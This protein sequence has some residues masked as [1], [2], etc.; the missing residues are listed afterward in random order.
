LVLRDFFVVFCIIQFIIV[1]L[2]AI[3]RE[4]DKASAYCV[5]TC[6]VP[7]NGTAPDPCVACPPIKA[8]L[9]PTSMEDH[10][11]ITYY[12]C[13]VITFLA[14]IGF[15]GLCNSFCECLAKPAPPPSSSRDTCYCGDCYCRC[16]SPKG[17]CGDGGDDGNATVIILVGIIMVMFAIVGIFY[18]IVLATA[19][20]QRIVQRHVRT[21]E[22]RVIAADYPVA[23]LADMTQDQDIPYATVLSDVREMV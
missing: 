14:L 15:F 8:V 20:F 11:R 18:G 2:G 5:P 21:L 16:D 12:V 3:I 22:L 4:I 6:Q 7:V 9:F 17:D 13:G 1:I 10:D 23:D 19:L